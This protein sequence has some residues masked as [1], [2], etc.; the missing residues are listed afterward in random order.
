MTRIRDLA[1]AE[2]LRFRRILILAAVLLA[3][4]LAIQL[5]AKVANGVLLRLDGRNA[6]VQGALV[7]L[8][9]QMKPDVPVS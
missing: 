4:P 3:L 6:S 5:G 7:G 2:Q 1:A 8:H 9:A